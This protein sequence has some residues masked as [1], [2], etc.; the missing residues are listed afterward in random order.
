MRKILKYQAYIDKYK[1]CPKDCEEKELSAYR[2]VH[3]P[4]IESDFYPVLSNPELANRALGKEDEVL[5]TGYALSLYKD[6]QSAK[7][8]Y[9]NN[10]EKQ[11]RPSKRTRFK[12]NKG[13]STAK[14]NIT[15]DDGVCD[16][17]KNDGHFNFFEYET[18]NLAISISEIFDN[19]TQDGKN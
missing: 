5:C 8:V 4:V 1:N 2:W 17:A 15:K 19:F 11:D 10:F 9:M 13:T 3:N 18:C 7:T 6:A 14:I 16:E 12:E